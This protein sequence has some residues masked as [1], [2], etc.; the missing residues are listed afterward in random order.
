M[1]GFISAMNSFQSLTQ[2]LALQADRKILQTEEAAYLRL[3]LSAHEKAAWS[4]FALPSAFAFTQI[5][6]FAFTAL[7]FYL[8]LFS[9]TNA[10]A[11]TK[12]AVSSIQTSVQNYESTRPSIAATKLDLDP[13]TG[14]RHAENLLNSEST[15][16]A[17]LASTEPEDFMPALS[18]PG[19]Y[20]NRIQIPSLSI[21]A[22]IIEPS[23]G[24]EAV[25]NGDWESLEG[26]IHD[27]LTSG[28]VHFPGTAEPGEKGNAFLTGHS[29]NVFWEQSAYNTV[30]AL[31][32]K[33]SVGDEILIT[34]NQTDYRYLV[35]E[36]KEV[37]P[38]DVSVL[39]QGD[40]KNL[41]LVTCTPVGTALRRLIVTAS[42][43]E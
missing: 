41:T 31:L 26:Q 1:G 17:S 11:Y 34:Y 18:T 9:I 38:K 33:I 43:V 22:P 23:L 21:N 19:S 15:A 40:S 35:T 12:I 7:A 2:Q 16:L 27:A 5:K 6:R 28:V 30:F 29:S 39:K 25:Q 37:S 4:V 24:L 42:L 3:D 14:E 36:K 8:I 32:P 20:E 10:Q 13:W